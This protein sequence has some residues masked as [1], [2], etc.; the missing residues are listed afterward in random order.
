[1]CVCVCVKVQVHV[2][3]CVEFVHVSAVARTHE[4]MVKEGVGG[5]NWQKYSW[6]TGTKCDKTFERGLVG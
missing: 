4:H 6:S 2:C 1:M 5:L 3:V